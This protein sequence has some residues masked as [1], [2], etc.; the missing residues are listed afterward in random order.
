[1][2]SSILHTMVRSGE[3]WKQRENN[4][5]EKG[6]TRKSS[7]YRIKIGRIDLRSEKDCLKEAPSK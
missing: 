1:V 2:S 5:Q 4:E 3:G 6:S 7:K